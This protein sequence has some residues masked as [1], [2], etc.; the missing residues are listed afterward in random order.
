[1]RNER[2]RRQADAGPTQYVKEGN[3]GGAK[4]PGARGNAKFLRDRGVT[5]V[6]EMFFAC[7]FEKATTIMVALSGVDRGQ[8]NSTAWKTTLWT[9]CVFPDPPWPSRRKWK[10]FLSLHGFGLSPCSFSQA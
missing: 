4:T 8:M 10:T 2:A 5:C 3:E 1:M 6:V 7:A 9:T